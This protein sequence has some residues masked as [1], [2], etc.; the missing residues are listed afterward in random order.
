M[1]NKTIAPFWVPADWYGVTV[2]YQMDGDEKQT[3]VKSYVDKFSFM[4][5]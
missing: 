4:F 3:S 1:L 5:W 2:N